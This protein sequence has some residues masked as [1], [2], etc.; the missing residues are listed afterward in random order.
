[1]ISY[2]YSMIV[3]SICHTYPVYPATKV[4]SDGPTRFPEG[5]TYDE[6]VVHPNPA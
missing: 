4:V 5:L 3:C 1:M 2:Y 6:Y